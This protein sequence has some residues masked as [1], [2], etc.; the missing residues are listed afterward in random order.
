MSGRVGVAMPADV[1]RDVLES[2]LRRVLSSPIGQPRADRLRILE[3]GN[4]VATKAAILAD[5]FSAAVFQ[6]LLV[7]QLLARLN[8][9]V[10]FRPLQFTLK[11]RRNSVEVIVVGHILIKRLVQ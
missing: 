7:C 10:L 3:A 4:I 9:Q 1:M 8:D 2:Q 11:L 5:R 6:S